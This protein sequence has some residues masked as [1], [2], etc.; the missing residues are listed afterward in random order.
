MA[1]Y[2]LLFDNDRL[3]QIVQW[4]VNGFHRYPVLCLYTGICILIAYKFLSMHRFIFLFENSITNLHFKSRFLFT[5][6]MLL[7]FINEC[8]EVNFA[9]A[10]LKTDQVFIIIFSFLRDSC[11]CINAYKLTGFYIWKYFYYVFQ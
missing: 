1:Y 8:Q 5:S 3:K 10:N 6:Y 7:L 11:D 9:W 4:H 2:R